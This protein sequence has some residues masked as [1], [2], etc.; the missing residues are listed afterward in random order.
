MNVYV[1]CV[2]EWLAHVISSQK[3]H[4]KIDRLEDINFK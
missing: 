3:L 1:T 4:K 2:E